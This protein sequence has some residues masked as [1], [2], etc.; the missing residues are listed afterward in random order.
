MSA[1]K[2]AAAAIAEGIAAAQADLD[3]LRDRITDLR[4]E[5]QE[6]ERTPCDRTEAER[7]VGEIINRERARADEWFGIVSS[8]LFRPEHDGRLGQ[9][10]LEF[11]RRDPFAALAKVYPE[12]LS[13]A[14]LEHLPDG[15]ISP[16]ARAARLGKV[17][18]DLLASEIAEELATREIES[19]TG[20][21]VPRR[22]DANPA[23]LLA[24]DHELE[25]EN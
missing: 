5:R 22:S 2:N 3:Q 24:P 20:G 15:G 12:Q 10:F 21:I 8:G 17:E 4:A 13:A 16:D 11:M 23:I 18:R 7:R 9:G 14:F 19:V 25:G 6:I 1:K